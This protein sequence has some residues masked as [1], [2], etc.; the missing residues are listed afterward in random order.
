MQPATAYAAA[1]A[2]AS[3]RLPALTAACPP[4][5]Q[6]GEVVAI[7]KIQVGEKGEVSKG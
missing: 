1:P 6:T 7:K 2:A 5:L 3:A 4:A